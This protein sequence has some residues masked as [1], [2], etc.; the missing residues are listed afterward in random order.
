MSLL[1]NAVSDPVNTSA[2]IHVD[3]DLPVRPLIK[4]GVLIEDTWVSVTSV[5]D[6][7]SL[8]AHAAVL[9]PLALW[10]AESDRLLERSQ[11]G[12]KLCE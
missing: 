1:N 12:A 11:A 8:P 7:A 5:D 2:N 3:S 4:D 9:V 6:L 10:Q